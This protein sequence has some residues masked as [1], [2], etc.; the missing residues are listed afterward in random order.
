MNST[1]Y[2]DLEKIFSQSRLSAYKKDGADNETALARYLYNIE[3]CK[4]LYAPLN[5]LEISLR[6]TIDKSL[7][8]FAGNSDWYDTL[9]FDGGSK[10]KILEAKNKISKRG[11]DLTHDRIIAEFTLGFWTS[12][13]TTRYSQASFQ[14][15]LIKNNLKKCPTS[16]KNIK[17]LQRIFEKMRILRN[18]VSHYER[19]VHW[20]D[21]PQ[22]HCQLL[23]CIKWIDDTAFRMVSKIDSFEN[24][25][26]S[27]INPFIELVRQNWNDP[28]EL[29]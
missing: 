6:N 17:N 13:I 24:V 1:F 25:Y 2:S 9:P 10:N 12:L 3:L 23:E 22:Q 11:K 7:C 5:V 26:T 27:G 20:N 8:T 18:S 14:S 19:I 28:F 21:L 16:S 29:S 4:S 15:Y